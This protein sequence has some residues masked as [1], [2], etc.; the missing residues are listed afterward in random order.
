MIKETSIPRIRRVLLLGNSFG[1]SSTQVFDQIQKKN[2]EFS[3]IHKNKENKSSTDLVELDIVTYQVDGT[4]FFAEK[5]N[6]CIPTPTV[7]TKPE[8]IEEVEKLLNMD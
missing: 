3:Q 5:K 7:D 8:Q 2:E 4:F 1:Q 6:C